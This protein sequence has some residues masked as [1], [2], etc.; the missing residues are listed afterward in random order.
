MAERRQRERIDR[1]A[2]TGV[3]RGAELLAIGADDVRRVDHGAEV[4]I[5]RHRH[6]RDR[7]RRIRDAR[8]LEALGE[9]RNRRGEGILELGTDRL[10]AGSPD[11]RRQLRSRRLRLCR[12]RASRA[13]WTAATILLAELLALLG[14][15]LAGLRGCGGRRGAGAAAEPDAL[16]RRQ[17]A[18][19][20]GAATLRRCHHITALAIIATAITNHRSDRLVICR[21][22]SM[23][24]GKMPACRA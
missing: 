2:Q 18:F 15:Q 13:L 24:S 9:D 6:L 10:R 22:A 21:Y 17:A 12:A 4:G 11:L 16:A 7:G 8:V 19:A 20:G 3:E 14:R 1:V 5:A 23:E